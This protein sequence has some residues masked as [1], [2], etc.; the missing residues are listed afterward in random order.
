MENEWETILTTL[1]KAFMKKEKD[2][3]DAVAAGN[4]AIVSPPDYME[5]LILRYYTLQQDIQK[6]KNIYVSDSVA[7]KK[8]T[9][10]LKQKLPAFKKQRENA[11]LS[12]EREIKQTPMTAQERA[13][14]NTQIKPL[15]KQQGRSLLYAEI[16]PIIIQYYTFFLNSTNENL[17]TVQNKI[18][19]AETVRK[20][21]RDNPHSSVGDE[22][23]W[24]SI[25][26]LTEVLETLHD[27]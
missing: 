4:S 10:I 14:Y 6:K 22:A 5:S 8:L 13:Y 24:H 2:Y 16:L 27:I 9:V 17:E 26:R 12:I 1:I 15:Q 23:L 7:Q 25:M 18:N 11:L 3:A 20:T 21:L 19:N